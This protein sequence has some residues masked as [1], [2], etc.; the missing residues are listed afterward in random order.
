MEIIEIGDCRYTP[1]STTIRQ[2]FLSQTKH[3][4][5]TIPRSAI[6]AQVRNYLAE[7]DSNQEKIG[8]QIPP[9]PQRICGIAGSG[10]T[11]LL[12]QKA[13]IMHLKHPDWKIAVVFLRAVYLM[14]L[15]NS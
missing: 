9:G 1:I 5:E 8:K 11:V 10:K 4:F 6:L 15:P 13:A 14:L 3:Q 7:L 2:F 12:C